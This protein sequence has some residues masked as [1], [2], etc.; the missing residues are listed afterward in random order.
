MEGAG[1]IGVAF[2]AL[3]V[4]GVVVVSL[5]RQRKRAAS[6]DL[7]DT[8]WLRR[9]AVEPDPI[10]RRAAV[11]DFHVH[12]SQAR[13]TF[14][15]PLPEEDDPVLN[16]LLV[17][18]GVEVV[19]EKRHTLPIDEVTEIVVFAGRGDIREVGRTK[20]PSPGELPTAIQ[21]DMLNLTHIARDP[22]ASQF[23]DD[24]TTHVETQVQVPKDDLG[25]IGQ[26]VKIPLGLERGLR[27][28]GVDPPTASGPE[29]IL[30]LLEMFGYTVSAE[31]D[32]TF[33]AV[34]DNLKTFIRA[35]P[36]IPG[37]YPELDEQVVPRFIVEFGTSGAARGLLITDKL[38]PFMIHDV[39]ATNPR[40]RF[41]TRE[42]IQRFIDS[43]A[44]G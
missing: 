42:R 25:P 6:I 13:V 20:L 27:T 32:G 38:G 4:L 28:R 8:S 10:T 3:V 1:G 41:V 34:K 40:I 43:M 21:P 37:S 23:E 2:I 16:D 11:A 18:E 33:T 7:E 9:E 39:E 22:F 36:H 17:D 35:E 30:A 14:D 44:L 15:V 31:R 26:E 12:G 5:R 29:L 24:L 19:R